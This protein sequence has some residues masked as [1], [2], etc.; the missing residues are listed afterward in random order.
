M[1]AVAVVLIIKATSKKP[2]STNIAGLNSEPFRSKGDGSTGNWL[3]DFGFEQNKQFK[4]LI[5]L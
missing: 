5:G 4:Q 1:A 2:N 3:N